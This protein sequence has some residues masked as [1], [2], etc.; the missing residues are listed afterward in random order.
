MKLRSVALA[1]LL[2]APLTSVSAGGCDSTGVQLQVLGS[3]GPMLSSGRA[4]ASYLVW[5]DG[6]A[7]VLLDSGAG[8]ALRFVESGASPAD[9]DVILYSQ[10]RADRSTDLPAVL[11]IAAQGA[12]TRVLPVYGPAG[13]KT[14]PS[15]VTFVRDLFDPARGAYRY[16]GDY[17]SPLAKSGFRLEPHDLRDRAQRLGVGRRES[18]EPLAAFGNDR[19]Q[20]V[21]LNTTS[22]PTP[23]LAWQIEA[24]GKRIVFAPEQNFAD[25]RVA[26][27]ARNTDLLVAPHL[28]AGANG[29]AATPADIGKFA[30]E[31]AARQL[32]LTPRAP[33]TLGREEE[34]AEQIRRHYSGP[35][36]FA[37][38]LDCLRP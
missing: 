1:C 7:R 38:D 14:M 25:A 28:R 20:A 19:V 6:K 10:L 22:A 2:A 29:N 17:L 3:G 18:G 15:T 26:Q 31:T 16:L 30:K 35:L 13:S 21:A 33:E 8:V 32:V 4:G 36:A 24:G 34:T 37:N 27:F 23:E 9:L 12:R 11:H 5:L